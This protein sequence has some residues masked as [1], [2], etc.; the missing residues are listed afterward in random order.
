MQSRPVRVISW[1]R[2]PARP[3][4]SLCDIS[5]FRIHLDTLMPRHSVLSEDELRRST[6]F[7]NKRDRRRYIVARSVLRVVLAKLT[8]RSPTALSFA[9]SS[10][11]RPSLAEPSGLEIDFNLSHSGDL[12][13]LAVS[14]RRVGV[15]IESLQ[16]SVPDYMGI[17][18]RY[19]S[20]DELN[21]L[22]RQSQMERWRTFLI[23][24]TRKEAVLKGIGTGVAAIENVDTKYPCC[25]GPVMVTVG[26][27]S[28]RWKLLHPDLD[29][30]FLGAVAFKG[31]IRM[32]RCW[33]WPRLNVSRR[34]RRHIHAASYDLPGY[35]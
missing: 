3:R 24:W 6:S 7:V 27:C 26:G 5:L 19:F 23:M 21:G 13:L 31:R 17:A 28:E 1:R 33:D 10:Q 22:I 25:H 18:N 11:G 12:T 9:Y 20:M 4:L 32:L 8:G 35:T 14:R 2:L 34:V 16:R 30:R 15:D 29:D